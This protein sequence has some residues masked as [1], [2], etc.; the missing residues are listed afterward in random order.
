MNGKL[1]ELKTEH[2]IMSGDFNCVMDNNLD[3]VSGVTYDTEDVEQLKSFV[4]DNAT[5][6]THGQGKPLSLFADVTTFLGQTVF[7]TIP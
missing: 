3:I 6:S 4:Y 5:K 7:S 2:K 1:K